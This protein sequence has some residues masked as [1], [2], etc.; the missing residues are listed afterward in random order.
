MTP[1]GDERED[2]RTA[3]DPSLV[4]ALVPLLA[5]VI[6]IGGSPALFGLDAL[7]GRIQVALVLCAMVA[8]LL[9]LEN[10]HRWEDVQAAGRRPA[11]W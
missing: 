9:A 11:R 7:D 2:A 8:A 10:G 6:L 4:D 1:G 3:R 5:L